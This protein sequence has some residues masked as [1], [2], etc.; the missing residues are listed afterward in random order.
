MSAKGQ[1][2]TLWLFDQLIDAQTGVSLNLDRMI[3]TRSKPYTPGN[4]RRRS[5]GCP[6]HSPHT[7]IY[8]VIR[9]GRVSGIT[10]HT[11]LK[12]PAAMIPSARNAVDPPA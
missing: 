11:I 3:G 1:K 8:A 4:Q 6:G 7:G 12:A 5:T 10:N 2:R 9:L